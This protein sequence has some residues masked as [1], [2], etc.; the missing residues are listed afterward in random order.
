M[1]A[2][3]DLSNMAT[4]E[5]AHLGPLEQL[6][7]DGYISPWSKIGAC[8]TIWTIIWLSPLTI[9]GRHEGGE[10]FHTSTPP[11]SELN[12][13]HRKISP[14]LKHNKN[15]CW[16]GP[17]IYFSW[18]NDNSYNIIYIFSLIIRL[19]GMHKCIIKPFGTKFTSSGIKIYGP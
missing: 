5:G 3:L 15:A 17:K 12:F 7:G 18:S 8:E 10:L 16:P 4:T 6:V 1:A 13:R 9:T 2:I 11:N 19:G 14:K